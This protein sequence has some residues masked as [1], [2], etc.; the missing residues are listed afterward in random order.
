MANGDLEEYER[1]HRIAQVTTAL[2]TVLAL[3]LNIW[4]IISLMTDLLGINIGEW[5]RQIIEHGW[6]LPEDWV[7]RYHPFLYTLQWILL[8]TVI[9]DTAIAYKYSVEGEPR[10]PLP[11]LRIVSFLGFFCGMWLYLAYHVTAYGLIFFASFITFTW[12]MFVKRE[13]EEEEEEEFEPEVWKETATVS[14]SW[15]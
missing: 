10:V 13:E 12:S 6:R 15:W 8:V 4:V 11:Y 3:L 7:R 1:V 9:V 14:D 2:G 5:A